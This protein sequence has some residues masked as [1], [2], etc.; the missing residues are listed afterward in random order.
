MIGTENRISNGTQTESVY[1]VTY[2]NKEICNENE[3][4]REAK[5]RECKDN[6]LYEIPNRR[7]SIVFPASPT[8]GGSKTPFLPLPFSG[9]GHSSPHLQPPTSLLSPQSHSL[10]HNYFLTATEDV[11]TNNQHQPCNG[12]RNYDKHR[13]SSLT[14]RLVYFALRISLR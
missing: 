5:Q 14:S 9:H 8:K 4:S 2:F 6:S 12:Y 7:P 13:N 1:C 11:N 10:P 3:D